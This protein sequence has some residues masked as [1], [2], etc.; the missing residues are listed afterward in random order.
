M[1]K[2]CLGLHAVSLFPVPRVS[3]HPSGPVFKS[4]QYIYQNAQNET[5]SVVQ[6]WKDVSDMLKE[7]VWGDILA[8][9]DIPKALNVKKKASLEEQT[10]QGTFVPHGR[11]DI[12]NTAIGRP[13][14]GG[15]VRALGSGV[16]I[17]QYFGRAPRGSSCS[18]GSINQVQ[19]AEIIGILQEQWKND[20]Q[21]LKHE[22]K[23]QIILEMSQR[24][25]P[26]SEPIQ[27]NIHVLGARVSTKGSNAEAI[28]NP[29]PPNHVAPSKPTMGLYVH[30]QD[31][32]ELVALGKTY[33]GGSTIYN[34]AYAD[35]VVRVSVDKVING[36]T[37]VPFLTSEIKYVRQ[38]LHTFVAWP[39]TLVKL[40]SNEHEGTSPSKVTDEAVESVNDVVVDDPLREFI[41]TLV[42]IYEKPVEL[43]WDV[44]KFGIPNAAASLYMDDWSKNLGV[45]S[46]YGFLEL[47]AI[48]S[49]K[50]RRRQCEEYIQKWLKESNRDVYLGTHLN[51]L[52][53]VFAL[54]QFVFVVQVLLRDPTDE[55]VIH[56]V[57]ELQR[58]LPRLSATSLQQ[59]G[60]G[61]EY[62]GGQNDVEAAEEDESPF[63]FRALE[64]SSRNLDRVRKLKSA[65]TRLTA[66]VQRVR[67]EL[68]QLLDDD[69]DMVDLY[70]SRKVGSSSPVSGS[71]AANWFAA[72]PTIRSKISRASLATIHLDENDVEEL[73]MLLEVYFS[74]IDHTL[75]KLTT[76][77]IISL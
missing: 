24:G 38:A 72:S 51:Y 20:I 62:L 35:D 59:K 47:Q 1:L 44:T 30:C 66:R 4:R 57:E 43:V 16:T 53:L 26:I 58:W 22:L 45:G 69:D 6:S 39:T 70:L 55:N 40:A 67:D 37:E 65:M 8:K 68:E 33:D 77:S 25:S 19:L 14:H 12:L 49:S 17:S 31:S 54:I 2:S 56:V 5:L 50:D 76:I 13:D 71:G 52:H 27:P 3:L 11:E 7:L 36:D 29:S 9:F 32:T 48:L 61:K 74:E 60:D 63:E 34:V 64:I 41:K 18:S 15:C 28:V 21:V 46:M 10:R 75:N 42:D 23:E 73:E